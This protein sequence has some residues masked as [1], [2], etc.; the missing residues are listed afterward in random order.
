MQ[1]FFKNNEFYTNK[2]Y[3]GLEFNKKQE[4]KKF[5]L[6]DKGIAIKYNKIIDN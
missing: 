6:G 1:K 3:K 4:V 2:L 5:E